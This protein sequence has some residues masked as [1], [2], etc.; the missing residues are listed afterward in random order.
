MLNISCFVSGIV[1]LSQYIPFN[2]AFGEGEMTPPLAPHAWQEPPKSVQTLHCDFFPYNLVNMTVYT[3]DT[4]SKINP[5][6]QS[7]PRYSLKSHL[8]L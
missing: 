6:W 4:T 7:K 8:L 1:L 3:L 5:S 2:S